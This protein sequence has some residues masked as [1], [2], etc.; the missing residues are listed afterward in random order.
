MKNCQAHGAA[1]VVSASL[2]TCHTLS[3]S[4][5]SRVLYAALSNALF[6]IFTQVSMSV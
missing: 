6:F 1:E 2:S 4:S 5:P 3:F